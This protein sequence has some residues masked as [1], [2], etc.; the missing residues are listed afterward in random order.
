MEALASRGA[1][2][3]RFLVSGKGPDEPLTDNKSASGRAQNNRVE[4][5][6]LYQ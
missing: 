5:V 1:D 3:K 2:T 6:F 4:V